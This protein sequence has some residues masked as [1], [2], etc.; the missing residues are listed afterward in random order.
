MNEITTIL[1][2]HRLMLTSFIQINIESICFVHV[3]QIL[4]IYIKSNTRLNLYP[5]LTLISINQLEL[6]R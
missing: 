5:L 3:Y 6:L 2:L 1:L 4:F